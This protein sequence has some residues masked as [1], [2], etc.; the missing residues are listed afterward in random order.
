MNETTE[1]IQTVSDIDFDPF[2][3]LKTCHQFRK[4]ND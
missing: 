4:E 3:N 2:S 1:N